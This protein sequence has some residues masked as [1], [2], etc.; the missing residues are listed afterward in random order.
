MLATMNTN[1]TPKRQEIIEISDDENPVDARPI[2]A[3]IKEKP[4]L[5]IAKPTFK[6][7]GALIFPKKQVIERKKDPINKQQLESEMRRQ[8][9]Q[10]KK[11][12]KHDSSKEESAVQK[13]KRISKQRFVYRLTQ[14]QRTMMELSKYRDYRPDLIMV[15][16]QF[17]AN[18]DTLLSPKR[19]KDK[20]MVE[21]AQ[22]LR[23][24]REKL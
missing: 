10:T 12:N 6:S 9:R 11:Y 2:T 17:Q 13:K 4:A 8:A 23:M 7:S 20:V 15:G 16:P 22:W 19:G 1:K 21:L 18:V 3:V 5:P 14:Q 24:K